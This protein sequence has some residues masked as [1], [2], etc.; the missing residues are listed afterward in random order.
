MLLPAFDI[1][2]IFFIVIVMGS[3]S[4]CELQKDS[5]FREIFV[6]NRLIIHLRFTY[7]AWILFADLVSFTIWKVV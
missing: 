2:I 5:L 6:R 7:K 4:L 1:Y 3:G